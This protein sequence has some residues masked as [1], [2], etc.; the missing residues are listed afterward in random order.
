MV[1]A[2]KINI[3]FCPKVAYPESIYGVKIT[4][5]EAVENHTL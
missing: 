1:V 5:I 3:Y 4:K 2:K